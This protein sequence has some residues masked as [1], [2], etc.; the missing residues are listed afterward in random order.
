MQ[1][2][3]SHSPPAHALAG[4]WSGIPAALAALFL[5][6]GTEP[7]MP[8][9]NRLIAV[10]LCA[11]ALLPGCA[12]YGDRAQLQPDSAAPGTYG[13][14]HDAADR[15]ASQ[16]SAADESAFWLLDRNERALL[17]RL[18]LTDE[19]VSTLDIQYFIW[20]PDATG[21][22]LLRRVLQA[23]D[24]GVRV[25]LLLDDFALLGMDSLLAGL[26]AHPGVEVRVY[27]PWR[28]RAV[29]ARPIELL[30]RFGALNSRMHNKVYAADD[31]FA[32][33]GGRNI[34]DRY[35]GL[36]DGFIQ[37]DL[38][39]MSAGPAT[40]A[41]LDTFEDYWT[42]SMTFP[43]SYLGRDETPERLLALARAR[44]DDAVNAQAGTLSATGTEPRQ[45]TQLL[46]SLTETFFTG[47]SVL[48]VDAHN[49]D[50]IR[51]EQVDADLKRL[52]A[53][54]ES[55]V[56]IST[57]YFIPD[58]E[59]ADILRGLTANGVRVAVVTNSLASNNQSIAHTGYRHWRRPMLSAGVELY[60][61]R[62]DAGLRFDYATPPAVPEA[63]GLHAKAVVVDRQ[64]SFI[65]SPN[66]DP[67][68]LVLNTEIALTIDSPELAANVAA[69]ITRDMQPENAWKVTLTDDNWLQWTN[70]ETTMGRQPARGFGQRMVEFFL[71]LL[72]VKNQL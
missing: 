56:L 1:T 68:S 46:D 42:S 32:I 31:R 50:T 2:N 39:L 26:N 54:A 20:Q 38:D 13:A 37:N 7:V 9:L 55:E 44:L 3:G 16:L 14:L 69:L 60:E 34:G 23:A 40:T 63:M 61:F 72:P 24:R 65:G 11:A 18:A 28:R 33:I 36:H 29:I 15:I 58:D 51:P 49:I 67:R 66:V 71:N 6:A 19:A 62:R 43:A 8:S 64:R 53:D 17:A 41:I 21:Y 47:S 45:W 4:L 5:S 35:F 30:F 27:N 57:P 52:V 48:H 10:L 22:L 70:D 25:R 59:F 12:V